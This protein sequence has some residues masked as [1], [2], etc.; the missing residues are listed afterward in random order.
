MAH[1]A[2]VAIER[3]VEREIKKGATMT[4]ATNDLTIDLSQPAGDRDVL[5]IAAVNE[6]INRLTAAAGE[7]LVFV[8]GR[9]VEVLTDDRE[10]ARGEAG[11]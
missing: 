10:P 3:H 6:T 2:A 1:E 7:Y 8:G 5:L 4:E 9:L 11:R